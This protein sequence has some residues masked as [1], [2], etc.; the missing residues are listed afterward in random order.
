[1]FEQPPMKEENLII[2]KE[3]ESQPE[4]TQRDISKK[5]SISLGKVNYLLKELIKKGLIEVKN[6][7]NN[8]GKLT[9]LHYYITKEGL[10]YKIRIT[11]FFLKEKEAKY[12]YL[13]ADLER[14]LAAKA[15][16]EKE[17]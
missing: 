7:S 14:L 15:S 1:M 4:I 13:K 12:I 11:Q 6:F 3:I 17:A 16:D 10:E 9:K 8:P 5:T 2:I